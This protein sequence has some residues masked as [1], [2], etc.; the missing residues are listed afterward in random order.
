MARDRPR[1]FAFVDLSETSHRWLVTGAAGFIG[2]HLV[3]ALLR[4]HQFVCGLD[5]FST[6]RASNLVDVS[7]RVGAECWARFTFI[8]G[9]VVRP[10]DV[11]RAVEG[12]RYVLHQAALGSVPKSVEDPRSTHEI[13]VTGF[14]NV[15]LAARDA[16]VCRV[17]YASSSAVYGDCAESPAREERIG[18]PLSPYAVSKRMNEEYAEVFGRCYG[19][20]AI[21]LRYFNVF[22]PRQDPNGAYAAV[23]PRWIDALVH[24]RTI[25]IYGDGETTRDFCPVEN[26]VHANLLAAMKDLAPEAPRVFNVGLGVGT[27]LDD[28]FCYLR[29]YVALERPQ[30]ADVRPVYGPFRA[31]DVRH[32]CADAGRLRQWLGFEPVKDLATGL[33]ETARWFVGRE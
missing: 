21:G 16:G 4:R 13:N 2:S 17:V 6:G 7:R 15:L 8:E 28:L 32:S 1:L 26:I 30:A 27:S 14:L 20:S 10:A 3:E 22:G 33:A 18:S 24:G 11:S 31:G 5:N 9:D 25:E 29:H 23:I 19:F 12:A